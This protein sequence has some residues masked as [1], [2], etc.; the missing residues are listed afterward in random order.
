MGAYNHYH[1]LSLPKN[2]K[3][4]SAFVI[5]YQLIACPPYFIFGSIIEYFPFS[6]SFLKI[7]MK[8]LVVKSSLFSPTI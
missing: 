4:E 3:K 6:L 7:N 5:I 2:T 8:N 1:L